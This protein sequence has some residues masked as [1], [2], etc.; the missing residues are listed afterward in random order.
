LTAHAIRARSAST[1]G[2]PRWIRPMLYDDA[3]ANFAGEVAAI[4]SETLEE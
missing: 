2:T 1:R 4:V 3:R